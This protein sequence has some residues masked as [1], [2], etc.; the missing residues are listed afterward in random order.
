MSLGDKYLRSNQDQLGEIRE[1][2]QE[3]RRDPS[4][5]ENPAQ[6]LPQLPPHIS[7]GDVGTY[8]PRF[9]PPNVNNWPFYQISGT[10]QDAS[11]DPLER[12]DE[13]D[14]VLRYYRIIFNDFDVVANPFNYLNQFL[15][16]VQGRLGEAAQRIETER[17]LLFE[18]D[19]E[20]YQIRGFRVLSSSITA[21]IGNLLSHPEIE[22]ARPSALTRRYALKA[23]LSR[24]PMRSL[25]GD[26]IAYSLL[27]DQD[28]KGSNYVDKRRYDTNLNTYNSLHRQLIK[29]SSEY[30][31]TVR[32]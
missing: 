15:E 30:L 5:E 22:K 10:Y 2:L 13:M 7:L 14:N 9:A 3:Q 17:D 20:I 21:E 24:L 26:T 1:L 11:E 23:I 6:A 31:K 16:Q 12:N 28:L 25:W 29:Q 8:G 32:Y 19:Q 4:D 27:L 18:K